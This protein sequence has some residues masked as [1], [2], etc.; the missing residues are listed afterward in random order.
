MESEASLAEL[1]ST[2]YEDPFE[3][4]PKHLKRLVKAEFSPLSW[5]DLSPEQRKMQAMAIDELES[6][7]FRKRE[8]YWFNLYSKLCQKER[9]LAEISTVA[10]TTP[11][12]ILARERALTEL[13]SKA[14]EIRN[15]IRSAPRPS[16]T[17]HESKLPDPEKLIPFKKAMSILKSRLG[18]SAEELAAWVFLSPKNGGVSAYYSA[19][20]VYRFHFETEMDTDYVVHLFN[21]GFEQDAIAN[22]T[23]SE[24]FITGKELLDSFSGELEE[25]TR[26]YLIARS[27][28]GTLTD[29]HPIS[30][31]SDNGLKENL[32]LPPMEDALFSVAQIQQ[33]A[34]ER[35]WEFI[36]PER[37]SSSLNAKES[38]AERK[39][40]L[41]EWFEEE[42]LVNGK[43]GALT[44]TAKRER[45]TPQTLR[46]IL[47]R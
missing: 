30:G 22:F 1:L 12:E 34:K 31:G 37:I 41:H 23:P 24:R 47:N 3:R 32:G 40:R 6:P 28:D 4:L 19:E 26:K 15:R 21:C 9:E 33:I 13:T 44:R 16:Q 46:S 11:S 10:A 38:P 18:A 2:W 7:E 14:T 20:R 25:L 36:L 45:I 43:R 17:K 8:E 39:A 5:Q 42:T 29:L 35:E 27:I